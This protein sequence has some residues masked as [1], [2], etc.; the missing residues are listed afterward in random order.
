MNSADVKLGQYANAENTTCENVME[1]LKDVERATL[2]EIV[3][4][5]GGAWAVCHGA[6]NLLIKDGHVRADTNAKPWEY[7][8]KAAK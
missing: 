3:G 7:V 2:P 4:A 6:V 8:W 1:F 5:T